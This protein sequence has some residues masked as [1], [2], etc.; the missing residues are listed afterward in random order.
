MLRRLTA[1]ALGGLVADN[2][3][4]TKSRDV[5]STSSA[6]DVTALTRR[7]TV[8]GGTHDRRQVRSEPRRGGGGPMT[9]PIS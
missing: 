9:C 8:D 5:V 6:K 7:Y 1:V 4:V 3:I 2:T